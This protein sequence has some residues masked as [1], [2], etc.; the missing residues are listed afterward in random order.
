M[1]NKLGK[2]KTTLNYQSRQPKLSQ[3]PPSPIETITELNRSIEIIDKRE[4]FINK[5]IAMYR[6][7]AR[8]KYRAG[9]TKPALNNLRRSKIY[10]KEIKKISNIKLS[11]Q[12]QII[13]LENSHMN[14]QTIDAMKEGQKAMKT[15]S[16]KT[17]I[18]EVEKLHEDI[19]EHHQTNQ[20]IADILSQPMGNSELIDE[21]E[22]EQEYNDLIAEELT[23]D[24]ITTTTTATA[25]T[26]NTTTTTATTPAITTNTTTAT[27]ATAKFSQMEKLPLPPTDNPSA[28]HDTN[29]LSQEY[30]TAKQAELE[31]L[32][33]LNALERSMAI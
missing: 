22:L 29:P 8:Q 21:D 33:E 1:G 2:K 16:E 12:Q 18:E 14:I 15:M 6:K 13:S 28:Y 20:E 9:K 4:I 27:T 26:T 7:I 11:L 10:E 31:E 23:K 30:N 5:K 3:E 32:E 25:I 19:E 24:L 17:K